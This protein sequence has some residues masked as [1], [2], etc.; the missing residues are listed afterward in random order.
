[1]RRRSQILFA[2]GATLLSSACLLEPDEAIGPV[3]HIGVHSSQLITEKRPRTLAVV[4]I[5]FSNDRGVPYSKEQV[6]A[7]LFGNDDST[8]ALFRDMSYGAVDLVG[9][10]DPGGDVFGVYELPSANTNCGQIDGLNKWTAEAQYIAASQGVDL[11]GYDHVS[12][13]Y[14]PTSSCPWLA[15]ALNRTTNIP[16]DRTFLQDC[17]Y[18]GGHEIIHNFGIG[19]TW[20]NQCAQ[21]G[22]PV[23]IGDTCTLPRTDPFDL[24]GGGGQVDLNTWA[25]LR[26]GWLTPGDVPLVESSGVYELSNLSAT[27]GLRGLRIRRNASQYFYLEAREPKPSEQVKQTCD[28]DQFRGLIVRLGPDP[29]VQPATPEQGPILLDTHPETESKFDA[30]LLKGETFT[31]P[32]AGVAVTL[33]EKSPAGAKVH[34]SLDGQAPPVIDPERPQPE[35]GMAGELRAEYFDNPDLSGEPVAVSTDSE[36]IDFRWDVGS[37]DPM[38]PSDKFSARW[39]GTIV[40]T[41]DAT[42]TL[43]TF[44]DDGVRLWIDDELV[45][46]RWRT[47]P[48]DQSRVSQAIISMEANRQ[49]NLRMEYFDQVGAATARLLWS[50][51][52]QGCEPIRF[53][54]FTPAEP[55]PGGEPD[56]PGEPDEG[57]ARNLAGGCAAASGAGDM[58][59][60]V[61]LLL[62]ALIAVDAGG[63]RRRNGGTV[64]VYRGRMVLARVKF[65]RVRCR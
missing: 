45:I 60:A 33:L 32:S 17:L 14:P 4:L 39:Q 53:G 22:E 24:M 20:A 40:P 64:F 63:R 9:K 43:Q 27:S 38:V 58:A 13:V 61:V 12:Y 35:L 31:D 51:D 25:K 37:P 15:V 50:T 16:Y 55:D 7:E 42:Y 30:A 46:D 26:L 2:L 59:G 29:G 11:S 5:S 21:N 23:P 52:E 3:D 6:K 62:L 18:C 47:S 36:A 34:V 28:A 49:Y 54:T 1:M 48:P 41:S 10:L 44:A 8:S 19:H 65:R 57:G 56:D